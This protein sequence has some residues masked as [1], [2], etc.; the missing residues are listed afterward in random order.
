MQIVTK[1]NL[2]NFT[3]K[4]L[5]SDKSVKEELEEKDKEIASFIIDES[6]NVFDPL[7]VQKDKR[8]ASVT[9]GYVMDSLGHIISG[10]IPC[11][12]GD[13]V[14][15]RMQYQGTYLRVIAWYDSNDSRISSTDLSAG[16]YTEGSATAPSGVS[17]FK[18]CCYTYENHVWKMRI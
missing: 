2:E 10:K 4:L 17:Y 3:E 12:D 11:N 1:G 13:I 18:L 5:K 9:S 8:F 6:P 15:V 7:D 14:R 16:G